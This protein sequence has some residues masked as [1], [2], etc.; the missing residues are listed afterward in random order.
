MA[1]NVAA[2]GKTQEQQ[3]AGAGTNPWQSPGTNPVMATG[4]KNPFL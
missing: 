1:T 4:S 3:V 2:Q